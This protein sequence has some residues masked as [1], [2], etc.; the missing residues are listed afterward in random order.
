MPTAKLVH[1]PRQVLVVFHS[2]AQAEDRERKT[3]EIRKD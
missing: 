1:I 2:I 3:Y